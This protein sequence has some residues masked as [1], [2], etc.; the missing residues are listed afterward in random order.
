MSYRDA[1]AIGCQYLEGATITKQD[2]VNL[3]ILLG[4]AGFGGQ[5]NKIPST[6]SELDT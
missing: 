2:H 3:S 4:N 5:V 6:V 1:I